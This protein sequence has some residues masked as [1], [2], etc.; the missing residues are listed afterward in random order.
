MTKLTSIRY[1][2][3]TEEILLELEKVGAK[4]IFAGESKVVST[5]RNKLVNKLL[6][7][8]STVLLEIWKTDPK[9]SY[10]KILRS[11]IDYKGDD[12]LDR[13]IKH[14]INLNDKV[15]ELLYIQLYANH[16]LIINDDYLD[17]AESIYKPGTPAFYNHQKARAL[18][19]QDNKEM[20]GRIQHQRRQKM[21]EEY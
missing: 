15:T 9:V 11:M 19:E 2:K 13:L 20:L 8:F 6:L 3:E 17:K 14:E 16:D 4:K 18:V 12:R 21:D 7:D 5:S 10:K 1:T